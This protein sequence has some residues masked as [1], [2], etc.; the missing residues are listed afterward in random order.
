MEEETLTWHQKN[1]RLE[2]H[3]EYNANRVLTEE[4]QAALRDSRR[5]KYNDPESDFRAK[6]LASAK[7]ARERIKADPAKLEVSRK[8]DRE[9]CKVQC[10]LCLA[11]HCSRISPECRDCR[12]HRGVVN[13]QEHEV[14]D[15]FEDHHMF[16]SLANQ[17]GRCRETQNRRR[18]DMVFVTDDTTSVVILEIDENQHNSYTPEC[19]VARMSDIRDQYAGRYIICIRYHPT[20]PKESVTELQRRVRER[21]CFLCDWHCLIH[22]PNRTLDMSYGTLGI[23]NPELLS[24]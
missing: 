24:L 15:Y 18:A 14:S 12:V 19:E 16:P 4:Q 13:A 7:A 2:Y 17:I 22:R 9:Y 3:K 6:M 11:F 5:A 23:L 10:Q 21:R 20:I 8:K 1:R